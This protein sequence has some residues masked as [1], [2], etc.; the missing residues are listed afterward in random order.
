VFVQSDFDRS[1]PL[2]DKTPSM[3]EEGFIATVHDRDSL[4]RILSTVLARQRKSMSS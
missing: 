4:I 1:D 2:W 3:G